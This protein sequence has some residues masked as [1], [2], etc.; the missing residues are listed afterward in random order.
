[1]ILQF[2]HFNFS[3]AE[4]LKSSDIAKIEKEFSL[5]ENKERKAKTDAFSKTKVKKG[6]T[7]YHIPKQIKDIKEF[8]EIARRKD[9][10]SARIKKNADS[11][12]FKVRCSRYLYTLVVKDKSKANKL[13]QSLPPALD[14]KDI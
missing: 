14:V 6:T 3:K 12:K 13:K 10:K 11:V 1:M 5:P 7:V 4:P 9:A 2:S 8:L